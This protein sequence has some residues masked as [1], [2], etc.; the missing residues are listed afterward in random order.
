MG[1][2]Y[3]LPLPRDKN[4][5]YGIYFWWGA[6]LAVCHFLIFCLFSLCLPV[7]SLGFMTFK[8]EILLSLFLIPALSAFLI[9]LIYFIYRR[10]SFSRDPAGRKTA[11]VW[12]LCLALSEIFFFT[13]YHLGMFATVNNIEWAELISFDSSFCLPGWFRFEITYLLLAPPLTATGI[14]LRSK[15][16]RILGYGIAPSGI[17]LTVFLFFLSQSG[18]SVDFPDSVFGYTDKI[19]EIFFL[20][21]TGFAIRF[22]K[23]EQVPN[24]AEKEEPDEQAPAPEGEYVPLVREGP[25]NP[26]DSHDSWKRP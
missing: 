22:K 4:P 25:A 11:A 15:A 21:L 12:C 13:S 9:V 19:I 2:G 3:D 6:V 8:E 18:V 14:Y 26:G 10:I 24:A 23:R 16:I 17:L 1:N 5:V 20:L 7:T